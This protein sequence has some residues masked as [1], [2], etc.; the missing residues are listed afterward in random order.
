MTAKPHDALFRAT[1]SQLEHPRATLAAL[2]PVTVARHMDWPSLQLV[3]GSFISDELQEGI[4]DLL[5][6][7][8]LSDLSHPLIS[9]STC[10]Q[11]TWHKMES[12]G[13]VRRMST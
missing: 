8:R 5:Y 11:G 6:T 2:L 12:V 13:C 3:P 4:T 1:F 7:V 10:F 9:V